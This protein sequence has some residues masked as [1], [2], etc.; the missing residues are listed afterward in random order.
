M[1]MFISY[2]YSN[3]RS[4]AWRLLGEE[5]SIDKTVK[6]FRRN[7]AGL[8]VLLSDSADKAAKEVRKMIIKTVR[9]CRKE[10]QKS[11]KNS[12]DILTDGSFPEHYKYVKINLSEPGCPARS[13][14]LS[15]RF[16]NLININLFF[17][18][19]PLAA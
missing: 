13:F 8:K 2:C 15:F 7:I 5:I 14:S 11:R 19:I 17:E 9:S 1:V 12:S 16:F 3:A 4:E 18:I 10:R 6:Y